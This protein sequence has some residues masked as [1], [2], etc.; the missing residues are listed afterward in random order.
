MKTILALVGLA[1]AALMI[2]GA[3][4]FVGHD[5]SVLV[6]PPESVVEDF[7]RK[8]VERRYRRAVS[9]LTTDLAKTVSTDQ[10]EAWGEQ[11]RLRVGEVWTVTGESIRTDGDTAEAGV[12]LEGASGRMRLPF[13][14]QRQ[15]GVWRIADLKALQQWPAVMRGK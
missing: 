12:I 11:L 9:D 10:I 14:L 2:D 3:V 4:V 6:P 5:V 7:G 13:S 1:A 8:M 15:N